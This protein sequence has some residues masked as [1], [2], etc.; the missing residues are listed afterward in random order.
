MIQVRRIGHATLETPD[1]DRQ[2]DYFTSIVGLVL[3]AREKD[4]AYLASKL[5]PVERQLNRPTRRAAPGCHSRWRPT[6][7]SRAAEKFLASEGIKASGATIPI[8]ASAPC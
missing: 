7:T 3:A 4:R 6:P 2:I 5:G 1:I 8:P